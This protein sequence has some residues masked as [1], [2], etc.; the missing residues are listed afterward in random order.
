MLRGVLKAL[1]RRCLD[2]LIEH[3]PEDARRLAVALG[4]EAKKEAASLAQAKIA[5]HFPKTSAKL[6]KRSPPPAKSTAL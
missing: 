3:R 2:D 5:E 6:K 1:L 4:E